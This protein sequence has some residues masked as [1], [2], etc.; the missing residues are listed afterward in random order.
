MLGSIKIGSLNLCLGLPNKR[1]MVVEMLKLNELS[2]CC[3]QETEIPDNYPEN[4]QNCGGFNLELEINGGKKRAGIYV[5]NDLKYTRR[6][7]LE[8]S[9]LHIVIVDSS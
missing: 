3:L 8:I 5:R 9:D 7:D 2:I 6:N 1:D 4:I